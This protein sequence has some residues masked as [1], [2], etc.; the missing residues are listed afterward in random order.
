MSQFLSIFGSANDFSST[1]EQFVYFIDEFWMAV[2]RVDIPCM[3]YT[4]ARAALIGGKGFLV[5]V[6]IC[7]L[8]RAVSLFVFL[9]GAG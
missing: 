8:Q 7:L 5:H 6:T 1:N 9:L 2:R 4:A 3:Q